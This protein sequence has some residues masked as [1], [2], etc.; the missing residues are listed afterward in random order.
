MLLL[1]VEV[2]DGELKRDEELDALLEQLPIIINPPIVAVGQSVVK[3]EVAEV[4]EN[5]AVIAKKEAELPATSIVEF[6][7]MLLFRLNLNELMM[8][9]KMPKSETK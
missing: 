1:R 7:R 2:T 4:K 8:R 9:P 3:Q 6:P 5:P